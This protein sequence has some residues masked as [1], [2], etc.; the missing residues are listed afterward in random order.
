MYK[1][2]L[3]DDEKTIV[4]GM[5]TYLVDQFEMEYHCALSAAEAIK[6]LRQ[7]RFDIVITDIN[8]PGMNGL[9]L[10]D[11]IK[12]C[13]PDCRIII[14]TGFEVFQ[15]AYYA[16]QYEGVE[17]LIKVEG[18]EKVVA[19]VGAILEQLQK[20]EE[21]ERLY[22]EM[23]ERIAGMRHLIR[24]NL[25]ERIIRY[26]EPLPDEQER[27]RVALAL[28]PEKQVMLIGGKLNDSCTRDDEIRL[29]DRF[30]LRISNQLAKRNLSV[31]LHMSDRMGF[32]LVQNE[33]EEAL[34]DLAVYIRE[35]FSY[36]MEDETNGYLSLVVSA[37]FVPWNELRHTF[38]MTKFT[39]DQLTEKE[40]QM[41]LLPDEAAGDK[42]EITVI[43]DCIH[44]LTELFC[45]GEKPQFMH[46]LS[47]ELAPLGSEKDLAA[48]LPH[49]LVATVTLVTSN[50]LKILDSPDWTLGHFKGLLQCVGYS[51]G[52]QWINDV[53][54]MFDQ[55]FI[56]AEYSKKHKADSLIETVDRYI[57]ENFSRDIS[58][59]AIADYV[60]YNPSYLSR[61]YKE[62]KGVNLMA[63]INNIRM[64][65]ACQ[66]L[67]KTAL[68]LK[69]I[70]G[71]TGFCSSKYFSTVFHRNYGISPANYR[72]QQTGDD[73]HTD[74]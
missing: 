70:S 40:T 5:R 31:Y 16:H 39:L 36:L 42:G 73:V 7:M 41:I 27:T 47:R 22:V 32:W 12:K 18:Y 38:F 57:R 13:W 19:R 34:R 71:M 24:W 2:L 20:Q 1:M 23:E 52:Q 61:I 58:L 8:M 15:Y 48:M 72:K 59:S 30:T 56:L 43:V 66:L 3:V 4:D 62:K 14:L 55:L 9:D 46:L 11:Y 33:S 37:G 29:M 21:N 69:E 10:V 45:K 51:D 35:S 65:N 60:H 53:L 44:Q 50:A 25:V 54:K 74:F 28:D 64:E 49:P 17:F 68:S 26:G 63:S 6:L 67:K